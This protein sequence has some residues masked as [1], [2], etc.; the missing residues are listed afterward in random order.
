MHLGTTL[1]SGIP[2]VEQNTPKLAPGVLNDDVFV[3]KAMS[4]LATSWQPAAAATPL[5]AASTGTCKRTMSSIKS[6]HSL[7][8]AL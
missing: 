1:A 3:A 6:L 8:I 4:Q 5:M 7:K 2:G